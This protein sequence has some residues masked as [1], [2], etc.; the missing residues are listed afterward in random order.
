MAQFD[1]Y[2]N[3]NPGSRKHAPYVVNLQSDHLVHLATRLCAPIKSVKTSSRPIEGLM[4]EIE[5]D[6]ERFLILMQEIAAV[7]AAVLGART[8]SAARHRFQL[9]SA[10]DLL[11]SGI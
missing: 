1:I 11:I 5:I 10:V 7:P 2:R 9:V 4:P 3:P 6:G 8:G